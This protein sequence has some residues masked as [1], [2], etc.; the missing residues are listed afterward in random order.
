MH[1]SCSPSARKSRSRYIV[2]SWRTPKATQLGGSS[3]VGGGIQ[4]SS[5]ATVAVSATPSQPPMAAAPSATGTTASVHARRLRANVHAQLGRWW[6]RHQQRL[7]GCRYGD[8][9]T[10]DLLRE[11]RRRRRWRRLGAGAD[12]VAEPAGT[13]AVGA[14]VQSRW[15]HGRRSWRLW[16]ASRAKHSVGVIG[17]DAGPSLSGVLFVAS[18]GTSLSH[19]KVRNATADWVLAVISGD[20]AL[21]PA[22]WANRRRLLGRRSGYL[23]VARWPRP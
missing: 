7:R 14:Y 10:L 12:S 5:G 2:S 11:H 16:A 13:R 3:G 22:T 6:S 15:S 18:G 17:V 4:V 20:Q 23:V 21:A 8:G 9:V 19:M 1:L